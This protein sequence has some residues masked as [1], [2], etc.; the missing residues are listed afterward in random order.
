M[1]QTEH[2]LQIKIL[3]NHKY[4]RFDL[5][6]VKMF[7]RT[8]CLKSHRNFKQK[9]RAVLEFTLRESNNYTP[10]LSGKR[11]K[12]H[13]ANRK[14]GTMPKEIYFCESTVVTG[15]Y[16]VILLFLN[17]GVSKCFEGSS[18]YQ[19]HQNFKWKS[20]AVLE[21]ALREENSYTHYVSGQRTKEHWA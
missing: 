11:A 12:E 21:L 3:S 6:C 1:G 13:L 7:P 20:Q 5:G 16:L 10:Y 19:G 15:L 2:Q 8:F 17:L 18:V 9:S 4:F 14:H